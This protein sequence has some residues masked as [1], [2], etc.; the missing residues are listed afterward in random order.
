MTNLEELVQTAQRLSKRL[1]MA[2]AEEKRFCVDICMRLE[3]LSWE[4]LKTADEIEAIKN[5]N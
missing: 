2:A 5:Y 3:Q 4:L 1:E